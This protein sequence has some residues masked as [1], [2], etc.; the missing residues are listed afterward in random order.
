MNFNKVMTVYR[1]E[2]FETLR[3]KRTLFTVFLLPIILYPLLIIGTSSVM[4][5]QVGIL[6]EKGATVAVADS[7]S[8]EISRKIIEDFAGIEHFSFLPAPPEVQKLYEE[9]DIQ[10]IVSIRDS[11]SESGQKHYLVTVQYDGSNEQGGMVINKVRAKLKETEN[12]VVKERLK[13]RGLDAQLLKVMVIKDENTAGSDKMMG[14]ILGR[15]LPYLMIMLLLTGAGGVA[16]DLVAGEKERRTLETLLVSAV[17]REEVVTGKFLTVLT[18]G[19]INVIVNLFGIS[20]SFRFSLQQTA[21]LDMAGVGIPL[22]AF[23]ILLLAMVPLATLFSS[24][25]LSISTFSRNI[26]EARTYEQPLYIISMLLG[27]ISFL[28]AIEMSNVMALIPI[29]NIALL[30]KAVMI[31]EY[32][33]SHLLITMGSTTVLVVF[34]IWGSIRL[35]NTEG[36]LFRA[37]EESGGLKGFKKDK[38][39]GLFTPYNGIIY[40]SLS[41]LALYYLGSKW[42]T[43]NLATGLLKSQFILIALPG[44]LILSLL[45]IKPKDIYGIKL[46]KLKEIV[47]VPFIALSASILV[48][49]L[50]QVINIIYPFP[51]AYQENLGRIFMPDL[52]LWKVLLLVAVMPGICEELMFR[53]FIPNFFKRWG[54]KA[55]VVITALLFAVFHLDPFRLLPVFLLG[56]LLGYLA[57]RSGSIINSMLSHAINNSL[58]L[59]AMHFASS[60]ALKYV[61]K[62]AES[63][64]YY[65]AIPAVL[66]LVIALYLFHK[67]TEPKEELQLSDIMDDSP[68]MTEL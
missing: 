60:K 19:M 7:V 61:M 1:K 54:M 32:Q 26:K 50:V 2:L 63:I 11:L 3:D 43:A 23:F 38:L 33:L 15:L 29:V 66:L 55:N 31:N 68:Q 25:L 17:K 16:G 13:E 39:K 49:L 37:E 36:V 42:Q 28:P 51:E 30:F 12:A 35:F 8:D 40:Y 65:L 24:I 21:E 56:L 59:L 18:M 41:L 6:E 10:G 9:K 57:L 53:G 46:P 47:L 58:A 62:D 4:M 14:M 64:H 22:R 52:P 48:A 44:L 5:R 34:A 20:L 27:M 67:A 45:K